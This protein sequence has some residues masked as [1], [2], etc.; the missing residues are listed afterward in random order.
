MRKRVPTGLG[1]V[2]SQNKFLDL[3]VYSKSNPIKL[4][5]NNMMY[6]QRKK[7][8]NDLRNKLG[9]YFQFLTRGIYGGILGEDY[10]KH[11]H[12][13]IVEPDLISYDYKNVWESKS[14]LAGE[15]VKL[16]DIQIA[17]YIYLEKILKE[18]IGEFPVIS[19]EIYRHR[20]RELFKRFEGKPKKE[21]VN[22]ISEN[23]INLVSLPLDV[24]VKIHSLMGADK[25]SIKKEPREKGK[26]SSRYERENWYDN[27]TM[28][29]SPALNH[30]IAYPEK[31]LEKW[32]LNPEDYEI[33][34]RKLPN[35]VTMNRKLINPFP[36]LIIKNKFYQ[37]WAEE[38]MKAEGAEHVAFFEQILA[39]RSS[40]PEI[41]E[42]EDSPE[43]PE[44]ECPF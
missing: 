25:I 38:F 26:F 11:K 2:Y 4:E 32:D 24:I 7:G 43:T 1:F 18:D 42:E 23:I 14:V 3:G 10:R 9:K 41:D 22:K 40:Y 29:H 6:I 34:K 28:L 13:L 39:E 31:T 27:N 30:F 36:V 44:E 5:R 17:K 8:T 20:V 12:G 19:Y 15:G 33:Q 35:N 16:Y 21:L 37:K